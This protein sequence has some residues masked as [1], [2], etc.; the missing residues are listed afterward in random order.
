MIFSASSPRF[1]NNAGR[2]AKYFAI[3][4]EIENVVKAPRVISNCLP[5]VTM[6]INLVGSLSKST[7]LAASL[8]A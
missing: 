4:L 6:S 8:A 5:I 3:S 7:M 1:A 2:I